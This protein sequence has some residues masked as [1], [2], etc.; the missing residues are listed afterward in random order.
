M[1]IAVNAIF[2]QNNPLEGFGNFAN[3]IVEQLIIAHPQHQFLL[4]Y[5]RPF[6]P[7]HLSAPNVQSIMTGPPARHPLSFL[8][9]YNW[10][11]PRA[12]RSFKPDI[13]LQPYGFSS[14]R[15]KI[16]QLLTLHDIAF[17]KHPQFVPKQQR[18]FYQL[19][20]KKFIQKAS[21]INTVSDFSKKEIAQHYRISEE[22][23][24][25]IQNGI[26]PIFRPLTWEER[27]E[28]KNQYTQGTEF[29]LCTGTLQ[30][31]KN[32]ITLL[33][34]FSIFKK[35]Q[36][37]SM[38][39]VIAGRKGWGMEEFEEKLST[40]KFREDVLLTGYLADDELAK[41]TGA[42][43]AMV[44]PSFYEGCGVP[45]LEAMQAGVPVITTSNS[46]MSSICENAA[47]YAAPSVPD[48]WAIHMNL[49]YSNESYRSQLIERGKE[50]TKPYTWDRAATAYMDSIMKTL[51][52]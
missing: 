43:Y 21:R 37:S 30:P 28:V 27:E 39:L 49:L 9:W 44:Y 12:I 2:M 4:V 8:T 50:M 13:L 42:A 34:A 22:H 24:D 33:K 29:F 11:L 16:P 46:A 32:L 18:L 23:I 35:R 36:R 25:V 3:Q 48:E 1:R 5:D 20:N 45:V 17:I 47:V 51:G 52:A 10:S 26:K 14:A 15:T 19:F 40:F 31:R 41:L 7:K 38:K 6:D